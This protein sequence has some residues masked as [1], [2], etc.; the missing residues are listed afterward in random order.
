MSWAC[1]EV[2]NVGGRESDKNLNLSDLCKISKVNLNPICTDIR[3]LRW[4]LKQHDSNY[5]K[6]VKIQ[7][8]KNNYPKQCLN[9]STKHNVFNTSG[10]FSTFGV[11]GIVVHHGPEL[12]WYSIQEC[13]S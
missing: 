3:V 2:D 12:H 13:L 4:H 1:V 9:N 10:D 8:T 7:T 6:K 5:K 11:S